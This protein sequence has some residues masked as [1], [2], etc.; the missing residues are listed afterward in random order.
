MKCLSLVLCAAV[1]SCQLIAEEEEPPEFSTLY[2]DL[3][4]IS[5]PLSFYTEDWNPKQ[6]LLPILPDGQRVEEK[7]LIVDL[8]NA[9]KESR[10]EQ[11]L[12]RSQK[13]WLYEARSWPISTWPQE[14][15]YGETENEEVLE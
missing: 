4:E 11:D 3:G 5:A 2:F 9:I 7:D 15:Y 8:D 14:G 6:K 13:G 12:L 10:K 1:L